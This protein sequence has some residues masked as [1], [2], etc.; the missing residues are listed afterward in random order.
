MVSEPLRSKE[1]SNR[2]SM[3][4]NTQTTSVS[5]TSNPAITAPNSL[6]AINATAQL[7]LKLTP[8]NYLTWRAQ[9]NA[10]LIGYDLM[11]YVDGTYPAPPTTINN[12]INPAHTFWIRQDQLLLHSIIASVSEHIMPLIASATNSRMAWEKLKT[13]YANR[14]R[15][16]VM[17]L[18]EQLTATTRGSKSVRE[19]LNTMRGISDELAIIGEP[20]SDI[21]LVVHI[22]NGIG[23]AFKEIAAAIRARD[24]PI[25]FEDL[26]DKLIEYE[27]FLNREEQRAVSPPITAHASH[28]TGHYQPK[29]YNHS[30]PSTQNRSYQSYSNFHNGYQ[31]SPQATR[32]GTQNN[33]RPGMG[34]KGFCQLCEQQGHSA[35]RCPKVRL[36]FSSAPTANY[37]ASA[38]TQPKNWLVDSAASHHVTDE[39]RNLSLT[40]PYEGSDAIVIGDGTGLNITHTGNTTLTTP[41][42]KFNL[43]NVLC[44]PSIKKNLLS[45]SKFCKTNKTSIEFFPSCF[46]V[47]DLRTGVPLVRGRNKHDVYEWPSSL[48]PSLSFHAL[49]G[50]KTPQIN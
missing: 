25:S 5:I 13:L 10:L 40:S 3:A 1:L 47:K 9:F 43:S 14:S 7:P 30:R 26:H 24:T 20:P 46:L 38:P 23:P 16:R 35:K 50:V 12:I 48:P 17:S 6:I 28:R 27:N 11:Q 8:T 39:L 31:G 19:F 36:D 41:S 21:D 29:H 37:T 49:A 4:E 15:S 34:Y 44:V 18:K 33:K 42:T 22:L 32:H 45:V 2:V